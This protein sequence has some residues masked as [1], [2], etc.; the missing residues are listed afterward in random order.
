MLW[1]SP[2]CFERPYDMQEVGMAICDALT[3]EG[4]V[5]WWGDGTSCV[6]QMIRLQWKRA[7]RAEEIITTMQADLEHLEAARANVRTS[8][9][10]WRQAAIAALKTP[11]A[12]QRFLELVLEGKTVSAILGGGP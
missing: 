2:D 9:H 8:G 6:E 1:R 10:E 12:M 7:E 5:A 11:E 4:C 3:R